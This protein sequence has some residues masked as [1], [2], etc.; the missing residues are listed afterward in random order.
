MRKNWLR[1]TVMWQEEL[2][3]TKDHVCEGFLPMRKT[4]EFEKYWL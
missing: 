3:Y 4:E 2:R 1:E